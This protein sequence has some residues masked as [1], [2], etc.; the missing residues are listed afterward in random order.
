MKLSVFK[1]AIA[2][3]V[4]TNTIDTSTNATPNEMYIIQKRCMYYTSR[5][6]S[7]G[8]YYKQVLVSYYFTTDNF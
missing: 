3:S 2:D 7:Y 8:L 1:E 4:L 5:N 6:H